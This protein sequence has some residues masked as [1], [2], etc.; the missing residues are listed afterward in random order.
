MLDLWLRQVGGTWQMLIDAL[1]DKTV[2]FHELANSIANEIASHD[3]STSSITEAHNDKGFE[4]PLCGTCS[5]EKYLR[6]ECP[7]FY[8][9]SDSAFPFLD[10]SKLTEDEKFTLHGRLIEETDNINQKFNNLVYLLAELLEAMTSDKLKSVAK[11]IKYQLLIKDP[12]LK[13]DSDADAIMECLSRTSSFINYASIRKVIAK[14]GTEKDKEML[15][16]YENDFKNYCKRNVF[17]V[18]EAVLGCPTDN[19]QM[20]VFKLGGEATD[21]PSTTNGGHH[22][23]TIKSASTL[24]MSLDDAMRTQIKIATLLDIKNAACLVF[25]GASKGC[26]E[27]KFSAPNAIIEDVKEQ[28]GVEILTELPG[29]ADLEAESIHILCG[30]PGKPYAIN[31]TNN[32]IHLQWSK[33]EYNG[34]HPIQ[35]YCIHYKSLKI[36]MAKWRT[37]QSIAFVEK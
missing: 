21:V 2:G 1:H 28:Y 29:Y 7:K 19:G 14:F 16:V 25:L 10:T 23:T 31:I 15:T 22:H 24:Q 35:H 18:P 32:S 5:L 20:L 11:F 17:E 6:Q 12:S 13:S 36:P 9:S 30:P 8:S 27:L 26:I 33:P 3:D 34:S 37:V 4:C